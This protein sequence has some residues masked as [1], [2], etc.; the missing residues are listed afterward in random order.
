MNGE[1]TKL[2]KSNVEDILGLTPLQEGLLYHAMTGDDRHY[3]QHLTLRLTGDLAPDAIRQAWAHV[4]QANDMLRTV[5]R[6]EG[7]ERPV[8]LVLKR[9]DVPIEI[10]DYSAEMPAESERLAQEFLRAEQERPFDLRTKPLR[11]AVCKRSAQ[12]GDMLISW[13]HILYDG[14]SNGVIMREFLEAYESLKA[15]ATPP[16]RV[17]TGFKQFLKWRQAQ[18]KARVQAYWQDA[19]SGL[20]ERTSLPELARVERPAQSPASGRCKIALEDIATQRLYACS[21]ELQLQPAVLFYG[22]WGLLLGR[23][24]RSNDVLFGTTVSGRVPAIPGVEEMV[25]LFINTVP[26]RARMAPDTVVSEWLQALAEQLRERETFEHAPLTDV[27]ACSG[28]GAGQPLFDSIVVVENYP[29][30]RNLGSGGAMGISSYDMQENTHYALTLGIALFD[31]IGIELA[32]DTERYGDEAVGRL[33]EQYRYVLEQLIS[34]PGARLR[35]VKLATESESD[36]ILTEFNRLRR[37]A[38]YPDAK[39]FHV[40]FERQAERTPGGVALVHEGRAFAYRELNERANGLARRLREKGVRPEDFVAIYMARSER[41]LIALLAVLKSGAAYVPID[42]EY[43]PSRVSYMLQD[44]GSRLLI[45]DDRPVALDFDGETIRVDDDDFRAHDDLN[46]DNVSTPRQS[47]LVLYTSGSTGNPKG[48]V[49]T[50]GNLIAYVEAFRRE[51]GLTADDVYLQQ[52][53]CAFDQFIEEVFPVLAAGGRIVMAQ[54]MD[55]LDTS[56]L[57]KLIEDEGVTIVSASALLLNELNK[58]PG[59]RGV[60]V[61]ISGGDVMK[62]SYI[63]HLK[64]HA[65]VYNT[66]GPTEATVCATYYRYD[67][68]ADGPIPIGKPILHYRVYVLD[69]AGHLAPIGVPGEICI[70]GAGVAR[71]YL[72]Q[73]ALSESRFAADPFAAGE[74]MYRT[75]DVGSWLPD[76]NLLFHGR[77]DNQLKIRGYRIEPG[78]IEHHLQRHPDVEEAVVLPVE[79]GSGQKSLA[80]YVKSSASLTAGGLRAH[81][82][83]LLPA[84]II[85]SVYYRIEG[86]PR[87]AN[88]KIDRSA[89]QRIAQ[90]LTASDSAVRAASETEATIRELWDQVLGSGDFG[91]D[92]PFMEVGGDSIRLMQL[93]AKLEKTCGAGMRITDLFTHATIAKQAAWIDGRREGAAMAEPLLRQRL[94]A[95]YFGRSAQASGSRT[96]RFQLQGEVRV[97]V[98]RLAAA[99]GV[100][101]YDI[102]IGALLYLLSEAGGSGS[103]ALYTMSVEEHGLLPVTANLSGMT[104]FEQLYESV[105]E[106]R[107]RAESQSMPVEQVMKRAGHPSGNEALLL[108]SPVNLSGREVELLGAFDALLVL[109]DDETEQRISCSFAFNDRRLLHDRAQHL[110][111]SYLGLIQQLTQ[112]KVR[113]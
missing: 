84:P 25:G 21:R 106:Q 78:E 59:M 10:R 41:L 93:H 63:T 14:W 61:F 53:S 76:G 2:D 12:A 31:G 54:R 17:K 49:L 32:Y 96:I 64:R 103:A 68:D 107:N 39:P 111:K 94:P 19:L 97:G 70:A 81:L 28:L 58:Q 47:A 4:I 56:G 90:P 102:L 34:H 43:A 86:V 22:A 40:L 7:M 35:D 105:S 46:P 72:N 60:R 50:H 38:E 100:A 51:F 6:W 23:Y 99:S 66:Y 20:E 71:G 11:I 91:L 48:V 42:H 113:S 85:P 101:R 5:Y 24:S 30:Q 80:A 73:P 89:L 88:G 16:A 65:K 92:D 45:A 87:T 69:E 3:A 110:I 82:A 44:S 9:I 95:A 27:T 74:R 37:P 104:A 18:S 8:Q 26:L 62:P 108:A 29:L 98:A 52:A 112:E 109:E 13:H 36:Q 79:T 75:G 33:A 77:N 1:P 57:V 83:E 55:V 15:G 67:G